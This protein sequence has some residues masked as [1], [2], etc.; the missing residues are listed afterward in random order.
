MSAYAFA[1]KTGHRYRIFSFL[2]GRPADES[3]ESADFAGSA[4]T[5]AS[6]AS[7]DF[8]GSADT[9]ASA[10]S[11][12]SSV[13]TPISGLMMSRVDFE[14]KVIE[15]PK[16]PDSEIDGFLKYRIRSLYPGRP[17][18]T[19]FDY[20]I[21]GKRKKKLAVLVI[22]RRETLD[23]Y[24]SLPGGERLFV[25]FNLMYPFAEELRDRSA[26]LV[27]W[28]S[29]GAEYYEFGGE[30]AQSGLIKRSGRT[31]KDLSRLRKLIEE[32]AG[33]DRRVI[34]CPPDECE[35]LARALEPLQEDGTRIEIRPLAEALGKLGRRDSFLFVEK[36][37]RKLPPPG[38]R[39]QA[40]LFLV[41]VLGALLLR[42][43]AV[44]QENYRAEL[45]E[46]L[47]AIEAETA[48]VVRLEQEVS[49]L[50]ERV[51]Q[52]RART[53]VDHYRLLSELTE[54]FG[55]R[56]E[57]RSLILEKD[58]F[59]LEAV[60]RDPLSLMEEFKAAPLFQEVRLLNIV[61]V[62]GADTGLELFKITGRFDA[63]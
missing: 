7:T 29:S 53:P 58:Y 6:T 28:H 15:L 21:L 2:N 30:E 33:A 11:T 8:A 34:F 27:F 55:G 38:L 19:V 26:L 44:R 14:I 61:P 63:E 20:R 1:E 25:P 54:V 52:L 13:S 12:G 3:T 56:A 42:R 45:S 5:A 46:R 9:A 37:E 50:Q 40:L 31:A 24:R 41:L 43:D 18:E 22:T 17:A 32:K 49:A 59:Q 57:I 10:A 51:E 48:E 62:R 35:E 39:I 47:R 23:A 60:G 36:K 16:I 4:D